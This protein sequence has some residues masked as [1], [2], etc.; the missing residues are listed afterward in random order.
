M[1][2]IYDGVKV[3]ARF[4][5]PLSVISNEPVF[6]SDTLSL[7]RQVSKQGAQRWEIKTNVEPLSHTAETLMINMV[8]RGYHG[9][10]EVIM[11]QN[12]GVIQ[13][14]TSTSTA[15]T[16]VGTKGSTSLTVINNVGLIPRGTFIR[17]GAHKKVYMTVTDL[18]GEGAVAIYP[19]LVTN[20]TG[21]LAHRDNVIGTFLY[22]NST[23]I[24]MVYSDGILM[25]PGSIALIEKKA[26]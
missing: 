16:A 3:I 10:M 17:I 18:T 11:P 14:R 8:T 13:R 21:S 26:T 23:V 6:A 9:A 5:V 7:D 19:K 2:G 12:Y 20:V 24:G 22:D 15:A 4:V 1:Y 25:D